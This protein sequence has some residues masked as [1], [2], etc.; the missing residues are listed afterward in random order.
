MSVVI[1]SLLY[2]LLSFLFGMILRLI[3]PQM[4][5]DVSAIHHMIMTEGSYQATYLSLLEVDLSRPFQL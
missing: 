2:H 3:E 5:F 1:K 4:Q